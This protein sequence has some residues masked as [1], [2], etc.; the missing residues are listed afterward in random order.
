MSFR[1]KS[2]MASQ[3]IQ[4]AERRALGQ[5]AEAG[6]TPSGL[7]R[8]KLDRLRELRAVIAT[9]RLEGEQEMLSPQPSAQQR[10]RL[11]RAQ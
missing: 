9:L 6:F 4:N 8:Y 1:S 10:Q 2:I 11:N 3:F 5:L 7:E